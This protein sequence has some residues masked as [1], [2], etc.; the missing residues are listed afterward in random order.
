MKKDLTEM[1][2]ILD[3]SG[4]MAGLES[5]TIGGYNAM[6]EKQKKGPGE[7]RVTT[8]LFDDRYE[9]LHD[10][11][12]IEAMSTITEKEYFVRGSTALLDAIGYSIQKMINVQKSTHPDYQAEKVIFVITTDGMENAS[13]EFTSGQIKKLIEQ[14]QREYGWEFLFLGANI[15]AVETA[16]TFGISKNKAVSY[17][18]DEAGTALNYKA[19]GAA[20]SM[21]REESAL[22]PRWKEDVETYY[23]KKS[24]K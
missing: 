8:V 9:L 14:Q 10:R 1:V 19:M 18:S 6:I 20:V 21:I 5:D 7:A 3:R 12:Q 13:R 16:S 4:S 23:Q 2:L 22:D 17:F 11:V 24:K 15:D